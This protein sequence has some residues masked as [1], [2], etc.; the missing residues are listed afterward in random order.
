LIGEFIDLETNGQLPSF[1]HGQDRINLAY[2]EGDNTNFTFNSNNS[3]FNTR[4]EIQGSD[5]TYTH[6]DDSDGGFY[7][8]ADFNSV[9]LYVNGD[10][11]NLTIDV[12]GSF[13]PLGGIEVGNEG[14]AYGGVIVGNN[15]SLDFDI[16][17]Q[18]LTL[19]TNSYSEDINIDISESIDLNNNIDLS[20]AG[21]LIS[22]DS[23]STTTV[24]FNLV[25]GS[26]LDGRLDLTGHYIAGESIDADSIDVDYDINIKVDATSTVNLDISAFGED[27]IVNLELDN[28]NG[29]EE[30]TFDDNSIKVLNLINLDTS[31]Q[32]TTKITMQDNGD[33]NFFINHSGFDGSVELVAEVNPGNRN[34]PH[35]NDN[36]DRIVVSKNL[37]MNYTGFNGENDDLDTGTDRYTAFQWN[38]N[39][40]AEYFGNYPSDLTYGVDVNTGDGLL[41]LFGF[42]SGDGNWTANNNLADELII[43]ASSGDLTALTTAL[44]S[45]DAEGLADWFDD[46][47]VVYAD[48]S[49][50]TAVIEVYTWDGDSL[51]LDVEITDSYYDFFDNYGTVYDSNYDTI[52]T[53]D[54][55]AFH[56]SSDTT[57]GSG[58]YYSSDLT[59]KNEISESADDLIIFV[60]DSTDFTSLEDAMSTD[61]DL[62]GFDDVHVIYANGSGDSGDIEV[63][64]WDEDEDVFILNAILEDS[65]NEFFDDSGNV[66]D[67]NIAKGAYNHAFNYF[68]INFT[69]DN[70]L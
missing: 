56:W 49:G 64:T 17:S 48:G 29:T 35:N 61:T 6:I 5:T 50:D 42:D 59:S 43:Y 14:I 28:L 22:S 40:S 39:I 69:Y 55:T 68:D 26:H 12:S 24:D 70:V 34:G 30:V 20:D 31:D 47:R 54:Y 11:N 63:Y 46:I 23:G 65:Y 7:G 36:Y 57:Y 3:E 37:N 52:T 10:D 51:E 27:V 15:S 38:N 45:A 25:G 21:L 9:H 2:L 4:V 60:S 66:Y 19:S 53:Y 67:S 18:H 32:A 33:T 8:S 1:F 41:D 13:S 58:D 44:G 62:A 16:D